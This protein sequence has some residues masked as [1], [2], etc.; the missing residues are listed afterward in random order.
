MREILVSSSCATDQN[1]FGSCSAKMRTTHCWITLRMSTAC[2]GHTQFQIRGR[3]VWSRC[4]ST[5]ILHKL[6][7]SKSNEGMLQESF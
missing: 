4:D 3:P 7:A 5:L 6:F 1:I 2:A